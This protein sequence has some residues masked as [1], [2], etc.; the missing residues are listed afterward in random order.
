M[1]VVACPKEMREM[2]LDARSRAFAFI[3]G[4]PARM[5]YDNL[6]AEVDAVYVG[7]ERQFNRR[8]LMQK[9][10]SFQ[11][12]ESIAPWSNCSCWQAKRDSMH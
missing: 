6:K 7:T 3:S 9:N 11:N 4:L 1:F 2:L 12:R 8:S 10:H 5:I